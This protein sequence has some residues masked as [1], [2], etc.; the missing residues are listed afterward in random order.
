[1]TLRL[2]EF[3]KS[4]V[5]FSFIASNVRSD[6]K[7][8]RT[9]IRCSICFKEYNSQHYR[10]HLRSHKISEAQVAEQCAAAY[11]SNDGDSATV[12]K[13][14]CQICNALV[15]NV[16][17]FHSVIYYV[18]TNKEMIL[19]IFQT[20]RLHRHMRQVHPDVRYQQSEEKV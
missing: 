16:L 9:F 14:W 18:I 4:K 8:K 2:G 6:G 12:Q 20:T 10:R 7:R 19:S 1:M 13:E 11:A 3:F 15:N 17:F 5:S